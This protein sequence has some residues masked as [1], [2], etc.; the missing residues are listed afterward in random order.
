MNEKALIAWVQRLAGEIGRRAVVRRQDIQLH[1]VSP[2]WVSITGSQDPICISSMP[3]SVED[4]RSRLRYVEKA[5][6][7]KILDG[8]VGY[9]CSLRGSSNTGNGS[10]HTIVVRLAFGLS[11]STGPSCNCRYTAYYIANKKAVSFICGSDQLFDE[12]IEIGALDLKEKNLRNGAKY[13]LELVKRIEGD[14]QESMQVQEQVSKLNESLSNE[15]RALERFYTPSGNEYAHALGS[16]DKKLRGEDRL[17]AEYANKARDI[18]ERYQVNVIFRPLS[19]G[20]IHCD[21]KI[22]KDAK[23]MKVSLPFINE[24]L[25]TES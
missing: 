18:I 20:T 21:V 15:L 11:L 5:A 6:A 8:P 12:N 1:Q 23:A 24:P 3:V 13:L 9:S 17:D 7:R 22:K 14:Y 25:I 10:E 2:K 19:L 4:W 16:L